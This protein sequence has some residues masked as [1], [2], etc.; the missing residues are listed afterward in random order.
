VKKEGTLVAKGGAMLG[1]Y[2]GMRYNPTMRF[3]FASAQ[4]PGHLD[5][6]GYLQTATELRRR[7][8]ELLWATGETMAPF[9]R[10]AGIPLHPL[11]ESGW[12]WPPPPPIQPSAEI[13]PAQ[14]RQQRALRALDQ[15]F[16]EARVA[17]ATA[18]L[19]DVGRT[20]QPDLVV[21]EVFL[22]AAGLAAEALA[23]P[24][25]VVGWPAMRPKSS[26]GHPVVVE[27]ARARLAR[28]C[29]RFAIE[30][31]NWS[32][33]GPPAQESP[34][35][36]LTYWSPSWYTGVDLLPQSVHVGGTARAAT[37]APPNWDKEIPW[38]FITLGT[39]FGNDPN[40][41][42][43]AARAAVAL[44][45]LPILALAGQFKPEQEAALRAQLPPEA[46]IEQRIDLG[47]VLPQVAAAIHHGGAGVTHALVT[48]GIPQ[49]IVPH[50]AD[51]IHQAQGVVRSGVG[52][53]EAAQSATVDSLTA[54][55]AQLLPDRA[56]ARQQATA[57]RQEFAALGGVVN[58][59]N[60]L[61][62]IA[63]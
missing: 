28:L 46:M 34:H 32:T 12:R 62:S 23:R 38:V 26:G 50:A 21:S 27:E 25:A 55:L 40:F 41:F 58:A 4:L 10:Q 57:L 19:I 11:Q 48:H 63:V 61:E 39:S 8:H 15:W 29:Q 14:L 18:E 30:G 6:G 35:L 42:I 24:F 7:G 53:H 31:H 54:K 45:C 52:Y 20:F 13:D 44:G 9:L 59:A 17:A 22:S 47:A 3:L 56:A 36:H 37:G 16:E 49:I 2:P 60:L 51:Q 1:V 33:V 43:L 5:W